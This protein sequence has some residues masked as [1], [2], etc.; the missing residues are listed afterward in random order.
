MKMLAQD[1]FAKYAGSEIDR[2]YIDV[3][4]EEPFVDL[5]CKKLLSPGQK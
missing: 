4:Y 3:K 1:I 5:C 2:L